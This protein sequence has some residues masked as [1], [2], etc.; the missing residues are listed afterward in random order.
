M[1]T[2]KKNWKITECEVETSVNE[3]ERRKAILFGGLSSG[4][5]DEIHCRVTEGQ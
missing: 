1:R 3:I 2:V 4:I 5:F